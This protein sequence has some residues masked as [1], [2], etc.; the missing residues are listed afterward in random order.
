MLTYLL[1][2]D[3][4]KDNDSGH[5]ISGVTYQQNEVSGEPN[6]VTTARKAESRGNRGVSSWEAIRWYICDNSEI[7]PEYEGV[8]KSVSFL[9]LI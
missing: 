4:I 7:Y 1:Y 9:G 2:K 5:T 8:K 3:Y 6:L